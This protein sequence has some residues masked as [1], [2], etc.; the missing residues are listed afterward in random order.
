MSDF[1]CEHGTTYAL[2]GSGGGARLAART[3][4]PPGREH[5][6]APGPGQR[7]RRREPV[8][9]GEGELADVFA[10]LARRITE[11]SPVT[12]TSGCTARMLDRV[13]Q[14]VAAADG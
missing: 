8:A 4:R 9:L 3:R 1:T 7:R 10:T 2:F 12:E 11:L 14:A 13:D 6:A 5:P